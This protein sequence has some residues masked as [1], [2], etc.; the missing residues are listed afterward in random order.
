MN[1][2]FKFWSICTA[3][4]AILML[5]LAW[6]ISYLHLESYSKVVANRLQLVA[7][8]R[9]G[10]V[11]QYFA[12]AEAEMTFWSTNPDIIAAQ[13]K[14]NQLW[15]GSP[16]KPL[17]LKTI[18]QYYV[19]EN[20]H[21]RGDYRDL[22]DAG[23]GSQYSAVHYS[24]HPMSKLFV[25]ERGYYDVF[26]IGK[27]GDIFYTVEKESDFGTNVLTGR[28][29]N[30]GLGEVYQRA[31]L[32]A[33]D[34]GVEISDMSAYGPSDEA[35]AIFMARVLRDS[36]GVLLGVIAFQLPTDSLL[37]TMD[38]TVG[39]GKTGEAY[40]VGQDHLMRSDSRFSEETT[41]LKQR[42]NTPTVEKAL[43]GG[44]GVDL[45][46]DYRGVKV[47]SAYDNLVLGETSWAVMAEIDVEEIAL[48]AAA[49]RPNLSGIL[50]FFYGLSLWTVWYWR[51]RHLSGDNSEYANLDLDLE[52]ESGDLG[53]ISG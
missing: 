28:W 51:G 15:E 12:T 39:M 40:L 38:Y 13:G 47:F 6:G 27:D 30:S 25:T 44:E 42:V 3:L 23:D 37:S 17:A 4:L 1:A 9:K 29:K 10:A 18:R 41:V 46:T 8:L 19:D 33:D 2:L 7:E 21:L 22:D 48:A 5:L 26:L 20:P 36:D 53:D 32:R 35:P 31:V 24:L 45:V 34:G 49:E 11:Q 52:L 14:L 50:L 16:D 43:A